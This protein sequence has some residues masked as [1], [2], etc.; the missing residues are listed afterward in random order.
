MSCLFQYVSSIRDLYD[1]IYVLFR[2]TIMLS[3]LSLIRKVTPIYGCVG[4]FKTNVSH[5]RNTGESFC[6]M[7]SHIHARVLNV[8][9]NM[10]STFVVPYGYPIQN[11][12]IQ[13]P[14]NAVM[15]TKSDRTDFKKLVQDKLRK[16]LDHGALTIEEQLPTETR[17]EQT[18]ECPVGVNE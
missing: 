12:S 5:T 14:S 8:S 4:L 15:G 16:K 2:P 13:S 11:F 10:C 1:N 3:Q 9:F 6:V 17:E 7:F 18:S